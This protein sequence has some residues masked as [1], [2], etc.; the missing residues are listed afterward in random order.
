MKEDEFTFKISVFG[1]TGVGKSS[2]AQ[3]FL[4]GTFNPDIKK[5]L[6]ASINVK[7][8]NVDQNKISLQI[9]DFGGEEKFR[10]LIPIYAQGASGG[11]FMFDLTRKSTLDNIE[12]WL[13]LFRESSILNEK[14]LPIILIG[15]K[16]DLVENRE[17]NTRQAE[18]LC[19]HYNLIQFIECSS[20]NLSNVDKIFYYITNLMIEKSR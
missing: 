17:V 20:K 7:I 18:K 5:T 8:I 11:L 13:T 9:W 14:D 16:S 2:L 19:K 10:F 3:S 4:T 1:P 15:G 12:E 6:G